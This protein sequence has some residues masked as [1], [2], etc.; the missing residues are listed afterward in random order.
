MKKKSAPLAG[1]AAL[2]KRLTDLAQTPPAVRAEEL[3]SDTSKKDKAESKKKE[4]RPPEP[5]RSHRPRPEV[6]RK[7]KG[8]IAWPGEIE[9]LLAEGNAQEAAR[10]V[11]REMTEAGGGRRN[12]QVKVPEWLFQRWTIYKALDGRETREILITL[13]L[14]ELYRADEEGYA[15]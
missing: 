2:Q 7:G 3:A 10:Q 12:I 13:L 9:G 4:K 14:E 15:G 11:L 6:R 1:A 8:Q 5:R